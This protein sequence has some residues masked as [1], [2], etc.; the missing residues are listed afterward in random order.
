[1]SKKVTIKSRRVVFPEEVRPASL[2]LENG[3]ITAIEDYTE[4]GE[5]TDFG[6]L[7]ILP[8]AIDSHVHFNA[9]GRS[10]WEGWTTGTMAALAG[11]VTTVVDMPLNCIPSTVDL[12]SYWVKRV[13][14]TDQ[15][16]CNVGFW[17]GAVPGNAA[18]ISTLVGA[19]ALGLKSFMSD[20]GTAEFANL[21]REGL[22]EAM[23]A[24]AAID[25]VLLLHAEWP[26]ALKEP[27]PEHDPESYESWLATRPEEAEAEAIKL[28]V[29]LAKET[30]CRC[31]IVHISTPS[32]LG[33]LEGSS[34]TCETCAHYLAFAAEE[35]PD[36]ATN[37]KCAPPIRDQATREGL[38]AALKDGR[39]QMV[40]S[41]HSPCPPDMKSDSFLE[42]WGGIAGVQM[43][44]TA[45]WSEGKKRGASLLDLARW[46]SSEPAKLAGL[47]KQRGKIAV[48]MIADLTVFDPEK[49]ILVDRLLHRH[50]GS[51]YE[52]RTWTGAVEATYLRGECVFQDGKVAPERRGTLLEAPL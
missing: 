15:L 18:H 50:R 22:K 10:D 40:T 43:L 13:S 12:S 36:R 46:T 21:D 42:S 14:S 52:G 23:V 49:S 48:G 38:W 29:E 9:P 24:V 20:P 47:D 31:H 45:T 11:G 35:I 51:P 41:D 44:L 7:S 26:A 6:D 19:G 2:V 32:V 37:F 25:S 3:L 16:F 39:I 8:G 33:L 4:D 30:N 5:G 17:G 1:M 34:V 27:V 28:V